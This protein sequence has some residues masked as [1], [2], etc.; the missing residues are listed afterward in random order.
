M[1]TSPDPQT[2]YIFEAL[3][4]QRD[5]L[6]V[7]NGSLSAKIK[8]LESQLALAVEFQTQ[9]ALKASEPLADETPAN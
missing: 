7:E 1:I 5:N 8:Q 4:N 9:Q 6:I 2:N 3:Q